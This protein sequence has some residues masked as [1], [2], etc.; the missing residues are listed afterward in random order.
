MIL[1]KHKIFR[2]HRA[3]SLQHNKYLIPNLKSLPMKLFCIQS[4]CLL[5]VA[6]LLA[7]C[8]PSAEEQ[9]DRRDKELATKYC[10]NCHLPVSPTLLDK[11][12]WAKHVLPAMAAKLGISTYGSDYY[13]EPTAALS[14]VDWT[15]LVAYYNRLAPDSL[16]PARRPVPLLSD[17][18]IFALKKPA[19]DTTQLAMTTLVAFDTLHRHQ[20]YSSD[21][22]NNGLFRWDDQLRPTKIRS[23]LTPAVNANFFRD[24]AGRDHIAVTTMG[25]MRAADISRGQLLDLT[26][27]PT[28][29][30]PDVPIAEKL[31]RPVQSISADLDRDGLMDWVVCGFGHDQGGLYWLRQQPNHQYQKRTIRDVPGACQAVV[32]DYNHDGW[33]DLMVLFAHADEGIFLFLNDHHGGFA[34]KNLL[35]FPSV[36]G[37]TSFQVVDLNADGRLDI[38]Y[39]C[40]DN[41]DYS[42]ILKPY[43]GVYMFLNEGDFRYKQAYFYPI[44]GCTKAIAADFDKDG[45]LDLTTIAF[46]GDIKS[47]PAETFIY[48]EQKK[49]LQF[50]PHAVPIANYGRWICMDVHDW[51]GDGDLD[52]VLGNFARNFLIQSTTKSTWDEHTP[53]IVLENKTN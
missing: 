12:T 18:A 36:Y 50:L 24:A 19:F 53:L 48:F 11:K 35:Q 16:L 38:L 8:G 14:I 31:P 13:A 28:H 52:V 47:Q 33:P 37:S 39:T 9:T 21:G 34:T 30:A 6:G 32:G 4:I 23:L 43:H 45:D 41:G 42:I 7:G 29:A 51:D 15:N 25:T 3:R 44:N 5:F 26:T 46:F 17:W 10:G 1:W 20:V 22:V 2:L 40:G 27:D 49:P